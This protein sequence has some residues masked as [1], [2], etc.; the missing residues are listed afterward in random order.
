MKNNSGFTLIE[1]ILVTVIIG[2]LAG[3]VVV[4]YG[5]Y[6]SDAKIGRAKKDIVNLIS[7]IQTYAVEHNDTYPAS[8]EDLVSGDRKYIREL[9][10]DP[11]GNPY[12]YKQGHNPKIM[13]F[14]LYSAG[15]DGVP[16]SEDDVTESSEHE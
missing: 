6:V 12:V 11:W 16:G 1:L 8:L 4:N 3:A 9:R 10:N 7:V 15:P 13:D 5:G 14:E 2:I